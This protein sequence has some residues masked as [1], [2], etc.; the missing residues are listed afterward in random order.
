MGLLELP[1]AKKPLGT[2]GPPLR[3]LALSPGEGDEQTYLMH[4][5]EQVCKPNALPLHYDLSSMMTCQFL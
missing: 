3:G 5:I 2:Q 1:P 4:G